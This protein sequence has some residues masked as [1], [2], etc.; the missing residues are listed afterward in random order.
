MNAGAFGSPEQTLN[1]ETSTTMV[2]YVPI[3]GKHRCQ[4]RI[5]KNDEA[6]SY[7]VYTSIVIIILNLI[8]SHDYK[9]T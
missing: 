2:F 6:L 1:T 9:L 4:Y 3:D 5:V 7:S 8:L